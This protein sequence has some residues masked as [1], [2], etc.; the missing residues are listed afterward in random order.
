[1]TNRYRQASSKYSLVGQGRR[2]DLNDSLWF[3]GNLG[4]WGR[5][6]LYVGLHLL[7]LLLCSCATRLEHFVY[8]R[9]SSVAGFAYKGI[10]RHKGRERA[11]SFCFCEA[12]IVIQDREK[13][14]LHDVYL[15]GLPEESGFLPMV[16]LWCAVVEV[17][18][19][20]NEGGEEDTMACAWH[21]CIRIAK[22]R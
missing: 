7:G 11:A 22:R 4:R 19:S 1:M 12:E 18:G 3:R 8:C 17:L 15:V 6:G 5:R 16:V 2:V 13:L 21:C 10:S 14:A 20:D 9:C